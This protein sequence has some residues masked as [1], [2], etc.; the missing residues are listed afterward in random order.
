MDPIAL[1]SLII[2]A[3]GMVATLAVIRPTKRSSHPALVAENAA[4]FKRDYQEM[5]N[6]QTVLNMEI[7]GLSPPSWRLSE[8]PLLG[9]PG[10]I[11]DRPRPLNEIRINLRPPSQPPRK[12]SKS[13]LLQ[14]LDL[15]GA[16]SFSQAVKTHAG[17]GHLTNGVIYRPTEVSVVDGK[18][19]IE[20]ETASYYDYLDTGEVLAYKHTSA[21][22]RMNP[23]HL[24]D[25]FDFR[26]RTASLGILT[27]TIYEVDGAYRFLIHKRADTV[28]VASGLYHVVPAGEFTPSDL[29]LEAVK[30]DFSLERNIAREFSEE[31]LGNSDAQGQGGKHIDYETESPYRELDES[32][33]SGDLNY[34]ALGMG[35]DP[36]T[37]KPELLTVAIFRGSSFERIFGGRMT[38][39]FEGTIV[40]GVRFEEEHIAAYLQSSNIRLGA[41]SCLLLSWCNRTELGIN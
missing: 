27:L 38:G 4:K 1:A 18:M 33:R 34:Y 36:L 19:H 11:F 8:V 39:N 5:Q 17:M 13:E 25:P 32:V 15:S 40:E 20:F 10:W 12:L 14:G 9:R 35:L 41:R 2:A 29:S 23:K 37:W 30:R 26:S 16:I 6:N 22:P 3:G 24:G 31:L 28:A 7:L 21:H